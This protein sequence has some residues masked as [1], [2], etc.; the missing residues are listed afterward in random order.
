MDKNS[1]LS[2]V[3]ILLEINIKE[4]F[5]NDVIERI[6]LFFHNKLNEL[7]QTTH[8]VE[9]LKL[10]AEYCS[11]NKNS[12]FEIS[13]DKVK[14]YKLEIINFLNPN[15]YSSRPKKLSSEHSDMI[16]YIFN[17]IC[18]SFKNEPIHFIQH[19][20]SKDYYYANSSNFVFLNN[21][22]INGKK[23]VLKVNYLDRLTKIYFDDVEFNNYKSELI[24]ILLEIK[25]IK[26]KN[27]LCRDNAWSLK[28]LTI[29]LEFENLELILS[30]IKDIPNLKYVYNYFIMI[31]AI[32][33]FIPSIKPIQN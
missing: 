20:L 13:D 9:F 26:F 7:G 15:W 3:K 27:Q 24:K 5:L 32:I 33:D 2:T 23:G 10:S 4:Q 28:T 16:N 30:S 14:T 19:F 8:G 1:S 22:H 17:S 18:F 25:R 31:D 6:F 11:F 21:S 29:P 12:I